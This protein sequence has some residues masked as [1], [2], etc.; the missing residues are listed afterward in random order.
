MGYAQQ[1]RLFENTFAKPF[2]K[3]AGGK[4]QLLKQFEK[5]YPKEL[6]EDRI[7]TYCEPFVGGASVYFE[8]MQKYNVNNSILIDS[9]HEIYLVYKVIKKDVNL[10]I[11]ILEDFKARYLLLNEQKRENF[12]YSVREDYNGNKILEKRY[13]YD[14]KWVLRAAQM[15]FLN[16]TCFNG[17]YRL[18]KTG[19]FNV[20]FGKYINPGIFDENNLRSVSRLLQNTEILFGDFSLLE[21]SINENSFVYFD[22]PY[23]PISTTSSFNS[24]SK[25]GFNDDEQKRLAT[26]FRK[27]DKK[28]A[29]LMLSNSDPKNINKKDSFFDDL[30]SGFRIERIDAARMINSNSEKRGKIKELIVRNY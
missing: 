1:I 18:N 3:W 20:P 5:Y 17:L 23:R 25:E 14:N 30:Y 2:L 28:G 13:R 22:P 26:T 12:F 15:I 27:L 4:T 16:K 29:K 8:I 7:D 10:L 24:Y 11:E 6:F 19:E 21:D 9:N